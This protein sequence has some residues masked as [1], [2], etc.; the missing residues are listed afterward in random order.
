MDTGA[1]DCTIP[2]N[3]LRETGLKPI[4]KRVYE[5]ADRSE[6]DLD[7]GVAQI[8]FMGE[9]VGSTAIFGSDDTEPLLGVTALEY[10]RHRSGSE[11]P[12]AQAPACSTAKVAPSVLT[13]R[14]EEIDSHRGRF[15][16]PGM[17]AVAQSQGS[18]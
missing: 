17:Q 8:E 3:R 18:P 14:S 7:I 12:T 5:L 2:G 4:G 15:Q 11:E 1:T 6:T 13:P 9:F 16:V 10:Y